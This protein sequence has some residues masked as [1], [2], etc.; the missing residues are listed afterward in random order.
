MAFH[1]G[2]TLEHKILKGNLSTKESVNYA[3]QIAEGLTKAHQ[4][5]IIH[6]DIKPANII[7]DYE[8]TVKIIDF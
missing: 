1:S 5:G 3:I 6:K 2:E 4:K 7:I 8:G